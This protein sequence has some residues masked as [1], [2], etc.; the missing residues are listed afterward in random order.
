MQVFF[1]FERQTISSA[2]EGTCHQSDF[3]TDKKSRTRHPASY[4]GGRCHPH[5]PS[6]GTPSQICRTTL[7]TQH[8]TRA[9]YQLVHQIS[10]SFCFFDL[11]PIVWRRQEL[12]WL[13]HAQ[14][15]LLHLLHHPP[16]GSC[17]AQTNQY[18]NPSTGILDLYSVIN[19]P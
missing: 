18:N 12:S 1:K 14:T 3:L 6:S 15:P 4:L 16:L 11:K 19:K 8:P 9:Q 7:R 2:P 5:P 17:R 10:R 13:R